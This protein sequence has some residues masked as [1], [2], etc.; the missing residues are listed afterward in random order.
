MSRNGSARH[1][2]DKRGLGGF[3]FRGERVRGY[4]VAFL[5]FFARPILCALAMMAL[6]ENPSSAAMVRAECCGLGHIR[7][8][9]FMDV[10]SHVRRISQLFSS[11][12]SNSSISS[13]KPVR[14]REANTEVDGYADGDCGGPFDDLEAGDHDRLRARSARRSRRHILRKARRNDREYGIS[15]TVLAAVM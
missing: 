10:S 15:G 7:R 8:R 4:V 14:E 5:P 1:S 2:C 3:G 6:R 13:P 9:S 11:T 12:R